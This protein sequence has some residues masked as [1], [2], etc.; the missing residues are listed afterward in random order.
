VSDD[1]ITDAVAPVNN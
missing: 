1:N